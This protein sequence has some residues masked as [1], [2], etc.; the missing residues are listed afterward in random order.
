MVSLYW[1]NGFVK[2]PGINWI[3]IILISIFLVVIEVLTWILLPE[4]EVK[5]EWSTASEIDTAGFNIYRSEYSNGEYTIVNKQ[6]IPVSDNPMTGSSYEYNDEH[7]SSG[8]TYYYLL[9]DV[10]IDGEITRHG[11]IEVLAQR[12]SKDVVLGVILVLIIILVIYKYW[13]IKNLAR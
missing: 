10:G 8:K 12:T 13:T 9:E 5:I 3:I 2:L 6:L 11:P 1:Y 7:V 4:S